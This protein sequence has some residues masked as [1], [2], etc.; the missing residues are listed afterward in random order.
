MR[1]I[2]YSRWQTSGGISLM[3]RR[4]GAFAILLLAALS[5]G[6]A[7]AQNNACQTTQ[8]VSI[9]GST[10]VAQATIIYD[11]NQG[12]CWLANANLAASAGMQANLG[13]TGINPNGSMDYPTALKWVAALNAYNYGSGYLD[14]RNWQLPVAALVDKTFSRSDCGGCI[15]CEVVHNA[16]NRKIRTTELNPRSQQVGPD[17]DRTKCTSDLLCGPKWRYSLQEGGWTVFQAL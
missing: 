7:F 10:P 4:R 15:S 5:S 14:H 17:E 9:L 16:G 2:I 1:K 3:H 13:V 8:P 12:V 6:F 11:P